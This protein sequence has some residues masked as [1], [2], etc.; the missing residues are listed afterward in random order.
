M[1]RQKKL[2]KWLVLF[3]AVMFLFTVL[4][5]AAD[6]VNVARISAKSIQNQVITHKVTGSGKVEGIRE[7]A[8]F[9]Y[10][11]QKIAQVLVQEGQAVTK[12]DVLMRLSADSL[13][14]SI[15][16]KQAEVDQLTREVRDL[17][18]QET[19]DG[20]KKSYALRRAEEN[21]NVAV[22][23]GDI[24]MANARME[25]DVARQKLQNFY[26]AL[27][28]T[29]RQRDTS[30]E[31]A[32]LDEIRS[33]EE[34][35]NQVI[36]QRNQEVLAAE[37]EIEDAKLEEAADGSLENSRQKLSKASDELKTLKK[38]NKRKGQIKAP[39]NGVIKSISAATGSLTGQEAAMVLY[40]TKGKLRMTGVITKNDLKYVEVGGKAEVKNSSGKLIENTV[41]ESIKEDDADPDSRI[42][43]ISI[44]EKAMNIGE[45]AE[46]TVS[47]SA[48]PY[49][50]C[51]PLSALHENNGQKFVYVVDTQDTV[52]GEVLVARQVE[53]RVK[54]KN[55]TLAALEEGNLSSDQK[56]IADSDREITSGSRVRLQDS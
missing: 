34:A 1:M 42:I 27:G 30:Q 11:G 22:E 35:L 10:E 48:G 54:D 37:R 33:R 12:G 36:M 17:E 50:S 21:Y 49:S 31:Q 51:V 26:D 5:R 18:S 14:K 41:V 23:N 32:L 28:F 13:K 7:R 47:K 55:E 9:A 45:T 3:F 25:V 4:S 39:I 53:V 44:P 24:N 46:F 6:S 19:V 29:D 52:L 2:I 8:V 16:E 15:S 38:L 40:E 20:E 43:S 56:V